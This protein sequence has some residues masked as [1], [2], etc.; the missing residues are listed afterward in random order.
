[1]TLEIERKY[2][3]V[4]PHAMMKKLEKAGAK[5][6]HEAH[7]E[8][9]VIY[10]SKDSVLFGRGELLRLRCREWPQ[11]SDVVLT[12]KLPLPDL[13]LASGPAKR[14]EEIELGVADFAAMERILG[15]L[16]YLPFARYEKV[17]KS[18][19]FEHEGRKAHVDIDVLPFANCVEIE[20]DGDVLEILEH[21]LVLDKFPAS[22]KSYH[23][24]FL[25]WR[26]RQG[27]TPARDIVFDAGRK[28][29]LREHLK[30][31]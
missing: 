25:E 20:A 26:T 28:A 9:N 27:L 15:Q 3:G 23:H 6:F 12:Y 24:L 7:F 8:T 13:E 16:G 14:R 10:D 31:A 18:Y 4:E 22:A 21:V 11:K 2:L 19:V 29:R 30:L 5:V 1:M 17:R